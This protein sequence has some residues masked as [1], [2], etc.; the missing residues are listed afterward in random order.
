MT[1]FAVFLLLV[2]STC[3]AQ[4]A[5]QAA[6]PAVLT[7]D[8]AIH[9][10]L[11]ENVQVKTDLL[12]L[13]KAQQATAELGAT[14][15]PQLNAAVLS[16]IALNE[17]HF[18]IPEGAIGNV[19]GI[20][21]LPAKNRDFSEPRHVTALI[22]GSAV[23]PLSQLYKI[24]LGMHASRIGEA[25]AQESLRLKRQQTVEQVRDSYGELVETQVQ[26]EAAES[27]LRA[28]NELEQ[29]TERRLAEEA[30]LKSDLL[31]VRASAGKARYQ[32]MV[33]R[34]AMQ[35][36]KEAFNRLLGRDI[37]TMF[38]VEALPAA[39]REELDLETARRKALDQ[40]PEVRQAALQMEKAEMDVRRERAEYLPDLSVQLS[41]LSFANINFAPQNLTSAGLF[42]EWDPF[43]WRQK[44]HK[45]EQLK[46]AARQAALASTD[47]GQ[48]VLID[49]D[50]QFRNL[51]EARAL[52]D[53]Q[54]A[55][56]DAEQ[57]KLR[58]VMERF[59]QKAALTAD[60]L[61]Q[62]AALAEANSNLAQAI[63]GFW[64]A[65]AAFH[66]ALGEE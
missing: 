20:G 2:A 54:S 11:K 8:E 49:V 22:H 40:R 9:T 14:R 21:P 46:S 56:R 37:R 50:A 25:L 6:P 64:R 19:P 61:Q 30:V 5:D 65:E 17:I 35:T 57:E 29:L 36:R 38:T 4:E 48:Q 26:L 41:Y 45:I 12:D 13:F 10:A 15:L 47:A 28:L 33:L 31:A 42:F 52:V 43:D 66:R 44:H 34:D 16:G 1:R 55:A 3:P 18:I 51:D 27:S 60:V 59:G 7:L 23:Q 39:A 62:Q 63:S 58:V 24:G 53:A 32:V